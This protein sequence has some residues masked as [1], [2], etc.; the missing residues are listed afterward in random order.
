MA[1]YEMRNHS[2]R[3]GRFKESA[4]TESTD[5]LA[6]TF[7]AVYRIV[8]HL[9]LFNLNVAPTTDSCVEMVA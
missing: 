7:A 3:V 9:V 6:L 4:Q 5:P 8:S 1:R 2:A